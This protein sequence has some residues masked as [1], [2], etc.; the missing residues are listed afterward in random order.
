MFRVRPSYHVLAGFITIGKH[1][2]RFFVSHTTFDV[3]H[4]LHFIIYKAIRLLKKI[5]TNAAIH[6]RIGALLLNFPEM[7]DLDVSESTFDRI[8]FNRKTLIYK[9]S[10]DIARLLLLHYHPDVSK[11]KD[12]VL[13]LMFDMNYLWE[14][15]VYVSF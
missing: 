1:Q 11:G 12:H 13:A 8:F 14:Q 5:N 7:P 3:E 10:I 2:E 6:S 4:K 9:K 15:F